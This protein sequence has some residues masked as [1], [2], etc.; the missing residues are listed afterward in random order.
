MAKVGA[1]KGGRVHWFLYELPVYVRKNYFAFYNYAIH[2]Y[3]LCRKCKKMS[4]NNFLYMDLYIV[5]RTSR[6]CWKVMAFNVETLQTVYRSF[7]KSADA[8]QFIN[9]LANEWHGGRAW[10]EDRE[11]IENDLKNQKEK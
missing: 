5:K 3:M 6:K 1:P 9:E 11:Y 2:D 10:T 8:G 7:T 4:D